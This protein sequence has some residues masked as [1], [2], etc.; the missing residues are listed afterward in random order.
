M[1]L[2]SN[3]RQTDEQKKAFI[4]DWLGSGSINLFGPP[5]S[6]KD[7]QAAMLAKWLS[8]PV[9][10]GGEILRHRTGIPKHVRNIIDEG[11]LA[12]STDYLKIITPYLNQ[13]KFVGHP[14]ILSSVGRWHG[15]E[16]GIIESASKANHPLRAVIFL[17]LDGKSVHERWQRARLLDHRGERADD[18][19]H[20]LDV[21]LEEFRSKTQPVI[22]FYRDRGLLIEIDGNQTIEQVETSILQKLYDFARL[23]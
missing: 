9:I 8:A 19:Q 3:P 16:Q 21:R 13:A 7:T 1:D 20:L 22:N 11:R 14:L 4:A 6:G 2:N 5:F 17:N 15:E 12:P 23:D 18:A 10:G